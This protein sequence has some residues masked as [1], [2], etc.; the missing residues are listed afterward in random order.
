MEWTI[1]PVGPK[2]PHT[3]VIDASAL[4]RAGNADDGAL[5]DNNTQAKP[6]EPTPPA[7]APEIAK[8]IDSDKSVSVALL[9][10]GMTIAMIYAAR[11][12]SRRTD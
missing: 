7:P 2:Y 10:S 12:R 4:V 3:V 6:T 11:S 8:P 1:V 5:P 9:L